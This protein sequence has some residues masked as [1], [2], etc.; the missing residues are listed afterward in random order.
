MNCNYENL[1]QLAQALVELENDYRRLVD[2]NNSDKYPIDIVRINMEEIEIINIKRIM[3][4][5]Q[6]RE[7]SMLLSRHFD[8]VDSTNGRKLDLLNS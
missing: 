1:K 4:V 3:L 5:D 2:Q 7:I 8:L 6:Y